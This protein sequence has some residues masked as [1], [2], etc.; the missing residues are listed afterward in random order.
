MKGLHVNFVLLHVS[1]YISLITYSTSWSFNFSRMHLV[2]TT[3]STR[4][5]FL[6]SRQN[7]CLLPICVVW[8]WRVIL[9][10]ARSECRGKIRPSYNK[11]ASKG[12]SHSTSTSYSCPTFKRL[13]FRMRSTGFLKRLSK[14]RMYA[15]SKP[16]RSATIFHSSPPEKEDKWYIYIYIYIYI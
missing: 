11:S 13:Q 6:Q 10:L 15:S 3:H 8:S 16:S 14:Q 7:T 1:K 5:K 4:N 2:I 12:N 9:K